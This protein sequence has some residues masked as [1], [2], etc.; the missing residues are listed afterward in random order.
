MRNLKPLILS[1]AILAS[2]SSPLIYDPCADPCP[3]EPIELPEKIRVALVLGS[4]GVK[5]MAHVGVLEEFEKEGIEVDLVVGCS[6]GSLVGALW[7]DH[8]CVECLKMAVGEMKRGHLLDIN[9]CA[10]R[11]GLSQGV[12][13]KAVLCHHLSTRDFAELKIPLILVATDLYKGE[14]VPIGSGDLIGAVQASCAVPFFYAPV[15]FQDRVLIDGGV[16]NPVPVCV[17]QDLGA[18]MIIAVD[19]CE[20]LPMTFPKNLFGVAKRSAEIAFY[21]QNSVCLKGADVVIKPKICN[22]GLF[23]ESMKDALYQAGKEAA[24]EAMPKIKE[25]IRQKNFEGC[26]GERRLVQLPS[27]NA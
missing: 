27:Y 4:G 26:Q 25:L 21:W 23:D 8:P 18:D 17:A 3:P 16:I 7:C 10:S 11:Y 14:L 19:L 13:M 15:C 2:C 20:L 6:A 22:V 9:L 1:L 5:G 24:Q 12:N